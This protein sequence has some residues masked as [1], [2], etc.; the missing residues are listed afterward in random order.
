[1]GGEQEGHFSSSPPGEPVSAYLGNGDDFDT[2]GR[3]EGGIQGINVVGA[4]IFPQSGGR[5]GAS[6]WGSAR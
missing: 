2:Y 1:M 6:M 4:F 3:I 5:S